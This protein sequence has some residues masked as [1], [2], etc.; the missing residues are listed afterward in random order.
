M[1]AQR[2]YNLP[3]SQTVK[4]TTIVIVIHRHLNLLCFRVR[5]EPTSDYV[6]RVFEI[7]T[8][9]LRVWLGTEPMV[10]SGNL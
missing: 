7:P 5:C 2:V 4:L 3:R 6:G 8:Y 10:W 9:T 1:F